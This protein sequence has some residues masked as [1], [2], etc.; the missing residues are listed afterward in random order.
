MKSLWKCEIIAEWNL[1]MQ[2]LLEWWR[3]SYFIL[4]FWP[5]AFWPH[6]RFYQ[7]YFG[8]W[9]FVYW[10]F[11]GGLLA[12]SVMCI[13]IAFSS[14]LSCGVTSAAFCPRITRDNEKKTKKCRRKNIFLSYFPIGEY[15][16]TN[17]ISI[18]LNLTSRKEIRPSWFEWSCLATPW[19]D[20]LTTIA[21]PV[22]DEI[23]KLKERSPF[24]SGHLLMWVSCKKKY[25]S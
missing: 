20:L 9:H 13:G 2:V 12:C 5:A 16:H 15:T 17:L 19:N 14:V 7:W 4:P 24:H 3:L 6:R 23:K 8:R 10:H 1:N 22:V 18:P 11:F 21:A 25:R